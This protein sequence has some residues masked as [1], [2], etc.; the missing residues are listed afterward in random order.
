MAEAVEVAIKF[1]LLTHLETFATAQSLWLAKPNQ[2][3]TPPPVSRTATYLRATFLPNDTEGLSVGEG[4]NRHYGYF[5]VDVFY[6]QGGGEIAPGR[7]AAQVIAQ[8]KLS[9]QL[10]KDGFT[11]EIIAPPYEG[12]LIKDDP[13]VMLPVRIPYCCF[14]QNP[15]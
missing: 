3:F 6:G 15:A 9:T 1:A 7:I 13:W 11:V 2:P 14:A 5:Q 10:T 4:S 12:P 8:F